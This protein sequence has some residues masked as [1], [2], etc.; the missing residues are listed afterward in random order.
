MKNKNLI[1]WI[2]IL[3]ISLALVFTTIINPSSKKEN[4]IKNIGSFIITKNEI[5]NIITKVK[6][7]YPKTKKIKDI[8]EIL[9]KKIIDHIKLNIKTK[10]LGFKSSEKEIIFFIKNA[11][12]FKKNGVF[13]K[14][15]YIRYIEKQKIPEYIIQKNIKKLSENTKLNKIIK[16]YFKPDNT[17]KIDTNIKKIKY[18]KLSKESIIRTIKIKKDFIDFE[19]KIAK[20]YKIPKIYKI[21]YINTKKNYNKN[22]LISNTDV[23][24]NI[25]K[26]IEHNFLLKNKKDNYSIKKI[27]KINQTIKKHVYKKDLIN[28]YKNL[29]SKK[30]IKKYIKNI[31]NI[32]YKIKNI[33]E[34][35]ILIS[36]K[37]IKNHT[38]INFDNN[39]MIKNK[40]GYLI[41]TKKYYN[42][43]RIN[44]K[45]I[46]YKFKTEIRNKIISLKKI[47]INKNQ[48]Y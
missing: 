22:L 7:K 16:N 17:K 11:K 4:N 44:N 27:K 2:I 46:K 21:N 8:D 38:I 45:I 32:R 9:E 10:K 43:I 31:E 12:I 29:K 14:E 18:K 23:N 30:I 5:D 1:T 35:T 3:L 15:N 28:K 47:I 34:K 19:K 26:K 33:K 40:N 39:Q 36:P 20:N 24:N 25:S 41:V 6:N 42:N 48:T 37:C 13:S